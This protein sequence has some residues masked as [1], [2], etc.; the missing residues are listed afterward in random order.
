MTIRHRS[1]VIND[2]TVNE[3]AGTATF[4]VTL[5]AASGQTVTVGYNTTNGTATA[6]SDYTS[7]SGT[8]TFAPGDTTQ[9]ITVPILNDTLFEGP[10]AET[11]NV[12]LLTPTNA[13]IADNLGIGSI[14]DN[15]GAPTVTTVSSNSATEATGI[16]HTVTLSN[17]STT[18]TTFALTLGGG[19]ATG[20]GTDYTS[21]LTNLAFSNGVT[22]SGGTLTVPAGVTSFTVT[23]PTTADLLDET[24]ET[25]NLSVGGVTG[26]GTIVDDDPTP[27]LAINDVTVNEAAGT[28]TFTVT[29]SA[30]SG[31]T[32]TVGY[33]T[34]NG[35]ATAGSDYTSTSGTLTFAPGDTT[36]TITVPILND[37]LFEGPIAETFNVNLLT[38]TNATIADNLGIGSITDNDG[39]PTVTTV[40]SNSATEA[41]GIVHTVTL[42]NASTTATTF[43][44]TLGGGSATGGGTD[45]TSTLT[46]LAFSNGVTISGGTLTVPAGV[47]SFTVTV[48]TTADLLDETNE[49][50]NLSV[51]G[52]TGVGTIV[53]D[54][55]TPSL[56]I[57]DVTVNE[58]AGTATFTVTL[59]A[60]S[61]QTV[62]VGYNTTN[63]TATAGSDY[64]ST[65]GTLTFAPGDTTQ[66][67]TVP[68]LNDTLFEG[69]IAE[70]F[71]VNLLTPTN[72]TIADNLGIGSITDNDGA[73]TVT[74][75][76]SNSA[77]E[78][79]GIVHT[80]TLSNAS[81][82][83]TTFALTLGGGSATGGGTDYTSTLTNLAFSNGVTISGGT[84]TVPAGVTSFTVTVPTTADLLDETNETYNLSVGGVTGVGTIVDDD[85]TPSL[86]I[87]D[88]TV[89]EAAG[90]ATFTVTLSAAS[91]Q[92]VTVGY[93][94]T[95][96]TATA[97]SDYTSTSG[98]LTFAPGDTTQTITVPI[99]NDT[100]FEGPI[101]ET[102]N[103]NLLT[104]TN[105][106]IADNLG[107]GS[108]TDND[109]APTVTT[110]SS[111]SATE[112]TGIVHTVTLSNASTTAT[113]FA[114]TLGG[115]SATGGGTD[116]TSTLTNLAFSNGVTISGGTLTVPAGVTSFTVTVPT[117]ADL[118]DETNE[119]Y[120]LSVGGVTGVGTIVDDDP[121]PSLAINDVTVNEAAGTATFTVT[122]SAASGQ[123]VTVGYNT[124]NGTATA[125]SDYTSTSGTLTFAPGDTTQTITVPILNDT[126]FEGPIAETFNVNLL[127]PTNAT[128]A[129]N[130]GIGSIT[131]N[132]GAPTVTTVSSNSATEATGIV[133]TVTL[134]NASTTATTFA[135][136]LGGGSAT[137]GG[138]DYTSTLTNLAFSNGVTISGGT[139]TV[140]AGVT[141]FTV[142]VP[143]TAD[144]LDETNETYNLSVG[145]VTG[146]GTIVDDD[147]TPSLAINDVTVNEAAGTATFTVTLSAASGQTVTV[148]YNTTN[149][150]ATAGSDYTSTSGTLTFAPG[151]TTQTITVPILND[152]LFE[153]PIAE[154]F[155][156][157][158]LTPTNATI[159]DN[160][161][162]GSITD[163]DG[164]PTVT[165]VSSNSATEATGIVHTVTLSNASTTATTFALTLGGGSA[166]GGGTDYTS[167]LTNLAFSN[168][169]TISGGTLTVPAGVTSFTVTVPTTADLLDETNETYNLSVGG[170]TG[171]GTIVDDDPTPSLAINDV[172]VNEAAGTATFTVTLS[173]ASGQTV[174]VG[175]NTT[176]GT[177]TAGSDYTSTSGT[178]TFAPG[179]TTQTITVP[180]LNDTLFEGPIAETFNVNLLTP[181]NAT[182]ADNLGI[183]SITDNDGAPTVTTVSSNSATEATGIVHTVTLSNA[184]TTATTFAL[185][186]GGGS[187]TG[188]GTDYTSTLTN[189]AFSNG[190]TISGGT[191]TVPAG[192]TSF[193]VTVPTTADLLDETNETYNLSVG[194]VTGVG[195][196]VD[197][198][199]TPSLA[200]N[201]VTVNE[202]A[203]TATFTV[204]L[205]AASGQTVTVGYNTTNGT[206][207]AGSDYTSTSGTLTFAPGDTTQ[208][209]T[210]PILNDTLFEGPIAETFNVNLLT[211]TNATIA[212]NL[213]VGTITDNDG[214][215]TV[216]TVSSNSATEATG[217]VHTVTLSNASTTATTFALTL[218]GGSATGG[219]TDYTSTLTNLAFSNGVT[220][221]GGTLTVPAG[222]TSFTVTVPTTADLLDETNE[223]YNLSVGGVTGVG[224][225]VDDDPT[226]SLAINDV[227]VNEAAG[228][229]TF[230]VTLSAA[231]GQTVTVG[232]NT[233]NGTATA[234]SDY[235][236]TSG[237]LTFAPGDTTQTITVPILNDTLF[238]GPIAETFNVNLLTPTNATIADNL[239]VG[240]I[241]DDDHPPV[242][243][244]PAAQS[245][246]EDTSKVFSS[247]NGNA[248]TVADVDG[249]TLT[250]TLTVI[251]GTLIA[252]AFAGATIA[253]N[254]TGT[255]TISG[256]SSAING[257]LNGLIFKPTGDYSGSAQL[258][259]ATTDGTATDTDTVAITVTPVADV[260]TVYAHVTSNGITASTTTLFSDNFSDGNYNGWTKIE[261]HG[262]TF[263]EVPGGNGKT[264]TEAQLF[265][266]V[267]WAG[268]TTSTEFSN[269]WTVNSGSVA[270]NLSGTSG[271]DDAQGMLAYTNLTA[272]QK[273]MTSYVISA[274]MYADADSS[275]ANGIGFVFGYVDTN[276]Y[277]IVRW[278]NPST[279]Y[280]PG[281]SLF[282]SYPGQY[283]QLSIVQIKAGV[284]IDLATGNF[285]GD[286]WFNVKV[287]VSN[288]GISAT[289]VDATS[290]VTTT[291]NYN[292][293]SVT[294]GATTAP[295]LNTIGFYTFDNDAVV[296]FDNL[297]IK[298]GVYNYTLNTEAYLNDVDGSESLSA[299]S[300]AGIPSGVTLFDTTSGTSITVTGGAAT[301][302]AGH[303]ITMTSTSAL[304]DGQIN[305]IFAS[306]TATES[307]GG[308]TATATDNAKLDILGTAAADTL[309]GDADAEW[310]S[311]GAGNDTLNGG[312]GN[313][314]LIGGAGNDI[315]DGG[316]GAD[317]LVWKFADLGSSD[318][319]LNFGTTAGTD[320]LDLRDLLQGESHGGT[321]V[322]N[323]ANYLHFNVSGGST[324]VEIKS[325]GS[326]SI[327]QTILLQGVDLTFGG[328]LTT[329]QAIIQDLLS[330]G[331]L[332]SD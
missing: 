178:L 235:T 287:T 90:T 54:D 104:P 69:P 299:I 295:A 11:F 209:I 103:V 185:T 88:V 272:T 12:N 204:T 45:Y 284:P 13:T 298:Q 293:G 146:V 188:G 121:T 58:A 66:T 266:S 206:A 319:V 302:V 203:G 292:Y 122:L 222:V 18:A 26:V 268:Q 27:S 236:S 310:I 138:T 108:I 172:T 52:V 305:S 15:D 53:D 173:A 35:T 232:Y 240:S 63:G 123:T 177:A 86:A 92:T 133:H 147:P 251:S 162:V 315:L 223:T 151:D 260:P 134:S 119:T 156:V 248:I 131:D 181:T 157:N 87:N 321:D 317:V 301:V 282:N 289:A 280:A 253:G 197:D 144:L 202:A 328:T 152:T 137:G 115:G 210:V 238:E 288:T 16:V 39:A 189:L 273:A 194:G 62:T 229:A 60:A 112:A 68:I 208:T 296:R 304:T 245:T 118:L 37:T 324:T 276:N 73:P 116:Y 227:T 140:P 297:D 196:I 139:L 5:S 82:T 300:L 187:A 135:L 114:L 124:T 267:A 7:T 314:V 153:G 175:Y 93:N 149:G 32:V 171:V 274:D 195:T 125:G 109:G 167:T 57:N 91:G 130:L 9:T 155:N 61:G 21:T 330:K 199:P 254:G 307:V 184:S 180:I 250:T 283:Q 47:T 145:G 247:A 64:T 101:A 262:N 79:T 322:G 98:T 309:S 169:V 234:G 43:A 126:L 241:L 107:I 237:T 96:G 233:T 231:S 263:A 331:K 30:A 36:Q 217:I 170:V 22:I 67:I 111:N 132:D 10:I 270:Y 94:T 3:A 99:L 244:V 264:N 89:N 29:L 201:D 279:E 34:T 136:T 306:V 258:Q 200:I 275:Q 141:S 77:T 100:L 318:T 95:N 127:T 252:S 193:T 218:G 242:N 84:L 33:N 225:I 50:Y 291:I 102:F 19:S 44:L 312:G 74:T 325:A 311:G 269:F 41:T 76:S 213:G 219:G 239:G 207:T 214:A 142:T 23:V 78:A 71:N 249:G 329:D 212:D 290:G 332:I 190:V 286:D 326:G 117:T 257:A 42:S 161:G 40:S 49:T 259:V 4:T 216:T 230:T 323:L 308:S 65:S 215:P 80:V 192:V 205:S 316:A 163:N 150:T 25:Y 72:A 55:P 120:N 228:T 56:A 106:T 164:A 320:A 198:D 261:L 220:I 38:P 6:G 166:T 182:I 28:A 20:G 128:I 179:D 75:V 129:D 14:T 8:L 168:G 243:T 148:G 186:L 174:T 221:S 159:A 313:D 224:T 183:G 191:L 265:A 105:A 51:G 271:S 143:T 2:V 277:Y 85:P 48:P 226:P 70:T 211:P 285:A 246:S 160:L 113:T 24:N 256:S 17:A 255:V 97:G 158:L 31:Q 81:T 278:E 165:T 294:N 1:L 83:A 281:G 303:P 110:V 154:T 46:N 327:D 59:S 176:N